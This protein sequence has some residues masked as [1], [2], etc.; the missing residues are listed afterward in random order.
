MYRIV[1]ESYCCYDDLALVRLPHVLDAGL[2]WWI[3]SRMVMFSS[4]SMLLA[5]LHSDV[6]AVLL[7]EAVDDPTVAL[8]LLLNVVRH[9]FDY[10]LPVLKSDT[11]V[12]VASVKRRGEADAVLDA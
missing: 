10:G 8:M 2:R 6:L 1:A 3:Q 9:L 12:Q 11:I 7:A 5:K 4:Q